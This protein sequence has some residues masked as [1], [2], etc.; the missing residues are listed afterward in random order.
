MPFLTDLDTRA[1]GDRD[2]LLLA[3]LDYITKAGVFIRVPK[4]FVTDFASIP[5]LFRMWIAVNGRHRHAATLH[6]YAYRHGGVMNGK[7]PDIKT[8]IWNRLEADDEFFHAMESCFVKSF[9]RNAMYQGV[10]IGGQS[11]WRKVN[12]EG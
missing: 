2:N 6:D 10:R 5:P 11:S 8:V 3:D 9:K 12:N 4:G 7:N 1:C